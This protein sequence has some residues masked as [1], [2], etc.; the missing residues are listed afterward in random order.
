MPYKNEL[1]LLKNLN[2]SI[3]TAAYLNVGKEW[4]NMV[5]SFAFARL[6]YVRSG[7]GKLFLS[8]KVIELEEGYMYFIP[9]FSVLGGTCNSLGHYFIH[10]IPDDASAQ[11]LKLLEMKDRCRLEKNVADY[12]FT[13]ISKNYE[14]DSLKSALALDGALKYLLSQLLDDNA[15]L[16]SKG[17]DAQRFI[18]VLKYIDENLTEPIR[19]KTLASLIYLDDVYFSNIFKATFNVSVKQYI[20]DKKIERAKAMLLSDVP[21]R[22][23]AETLDFYDAASFSNYFKKKTGLT[24]KAFKLKVMTNT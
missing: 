11:I 23:I 12:F 19:I 1:G 15:S 8:N 14:K 9:S 3:E 18:P 22:S 21:V 7:S 10:L 16:D 20:M 4:E 2:L 6:Y 17:T 24:P 5:E 13:F